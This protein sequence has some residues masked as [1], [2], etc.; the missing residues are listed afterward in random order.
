MSASAFTIMF[1]PLLINKKSNHGRSLLDLPLE[2][3]H[4]IY[5]YFITNSTMTVCT[6]DNISVKFDWPHPLRVL[7]QVNHEIYLYILAKSKFRIEKFPG[8]ELGFKRRKDILRGTMLRGLRVLHVHIF[9]CSAFPKELDTLTSVVD[10][11][12]PLCGLGMLQKVIVTHHH[13]TSASKVPYQSISLHQF[14][15]DLAELLEQ[16]GQEVTVEWHGC[17]LPVTALE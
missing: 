8:R 16:D 7:I 3:R 2:L 4:M 14:E 17:G 9:S 12:K 6:Y 5:G 13:F 15:Q 10:F 1:R 11:L